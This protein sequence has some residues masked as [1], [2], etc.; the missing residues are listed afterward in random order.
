MTDALIGQ[1]LGSYRLTRLI[2]RT[3]MSMVYLARDDKLDRDVVVKVML[4]DH[5]DDEAFAERFHTEALATA[6]LSHPNI[7]HIY[8][9]GRRDDLYY[10]VMEYMPG[11]SLY[12]RLVEASAKSQPVDVAQAVQIVGVIAQALDHAHRAGFVHRDVK[13]S[14]ILFSQDGHPVLTD[15]GIVKSREGPQLTLSQAAVGTPEYISPEQGRGDPVDARSDVYSLGV[16]LYELLGGRLPFQAETTWGMIYKHLHETPPP[17]QTLNRSISPALR[18][19]VEK[20]L[21][22]RP[23]DRFES[24]RT[25]AEALKRAEVAPGRRLYPP[26]PPPPQPDP[27]EFAEEIAAD[28]ARRGPRRVTGKTDV[29]LHPGR[30]TPKPGTSQR[31]ATPRWLLIVAVPLLMIAAVS[32]ITG[33]LNTDRSG[34]VEGQATIA[35]PV[36]LVPTFT[37]TAISKPTNT[38]STVTPPD[39]NAPEKTSQPGV[40]IATGRQVTPKAT[41]TVDLAFPDG[42]V[43]MM[44]YVDPLNRFGLSVPE[45]WTRTADSFGLSFESPDRMA[46]IM[47]HRIALSS[48]EESAEAI[49]R[50]Y[51]EGAEALFNDI[52]EIESSPV[53]IPTAPAFEQQLEAEVLNVPVRVR[54]LAINAGDAGLVIATA[55]STASEPDYR[56]LLGT[57]MK[58]VRVPWN[59]AEPIRPTATKTTRAVQEPTL[60]PTFTRP[61]APTQ[62][63][64]M[65]PRPTARSFPTETP[66]IPAQTAGNLPAPMLLNP[67][68]NET[69]AGSTIFIWRWDGPPLSANQGFEVRI[70]KTGQPD[71]FGAAEPTNNTRLTIDV[72]KAYGPRLGG[73]GWYFWTVAVVQ[74]S[75]Y[76]RI[77]P[78]AAP[79]QIQVQVESSGGGGNVAATWTPPPP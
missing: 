11:G 37:A 49:A 68:H 25:F 24:A 58:S 56:L 54:L 67:G 15:L 4:P 66:R 78:E 62:I 41:T 26:P 50:R 13:P 79:R 55:A 17:L 76:A 44:P 14:N 77:A 75:P 7:I 21:A 36:T 6:R 65:P 3:S 39:T 74:R 72:P 60:A 29:D 19:V 2:R 42:Q 57:V 16:V 64:T 73:P 33:A 51:V 1:Q 31:G 10:M 40:T 35:G 12:D 23:E 53:R 43:A 34:A 20:A 28:K 22:K 47:V 63:P 70:W 38:V 59:S 27:N 61:P 48:P 45:R 52:R 5:I 69:S 30:K 18:S 8:D 9:F 46:R 32:A 71:H